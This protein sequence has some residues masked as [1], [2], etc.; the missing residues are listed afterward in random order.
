MEKEKLK[1]TYKMFFLDEED[2]N[3]L[4]KDLPYMT[5]EKLKDSL[6]FANPKTG[7]AYIR[8]TGVAELDD[9]TLEHEF[10]ELLAKTSPDEIDGIRYKK[11]GALRTVLPVLAAFIPGIGPIVSAALNVGM[12]QYAQSRHPEEL[13]KPS[14]GSALMQGA[15]GY[16][17]GQ[18]AQGAIRGGT[19]AAAGFGNKLGGILGG[20]LGMTPAAS[21]TKAGQAALGLGAAPM[22]GPVTASQSAMGYTN[23]SQVPSNILGS[24]AADV[25]AKTLGSLQGPVTSAQAAQGY[26]NLSQVPM[27]GA[28]LNIK[29]QTGTP[30]LLGQ[31]PASTSTLNAATG[32]A[33]AAPVT[34]EPT[35]MSRLGSILKKPETILGGASI[36]GSMAGEQPTMEE[37]DIESI[38]SGL[39]SGEGL[40]PLG[41]QA[42]T[43]LSEIMKAKP[44]ELYP[45][46]TDEYYNAAFRQ[47]REAYKRAQ[48]SL[49]QRYNLID[50]NYQQNGE[51]QYLASRL[52]QELADI[53]K[54]F[55]VTE[56]QRRFELGRSTQYRAI[57]DALAVDDAAMQELLGF[58]GLSVKQASDKYAVEAG[59]V[60]E[61]RRAL[62]NLGGQLITSGITNK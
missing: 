15:S 9:T 8:K 14:F 52:D 61:L 38:V 49:A 44:G 62:G 33:G 34:A 22:Q 46:A 42:R 51:Y 2:F 12:N 58:T 40:S 17:G 21:T 32:T 27:G 56:E 59:D 36:L 37:V 16:F 57:K 53:E 18:A 43:S 54:D 1:P 20:A 26:T 3:N 50:P 48:E 55:S 31:T 11:G 41:Q 25:A 45:T 7:E 28:V 19:A 23:L 47:T 60:D 30:N 6:G 5:K 10:N 24:A 39:K 13:G 29:P 35:L 4:D